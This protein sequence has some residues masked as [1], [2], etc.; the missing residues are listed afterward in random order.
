MIVNFFLITIIP[1]VIFCL[2]LL[3]PSSIR[4][5]KYKRF[6]ISL[7][8]NS[9]LY[10]FYYVSIDLVVRVLVPYFLAEELISSYLYD[11]NLVSL[12]VAGYSLC[13]ALIHAFILK[14][15][16]LPDFKYLL[17]LLL[18]LTLSCYLFYLFMISVNLSIHTYI[19]L[20]FTAALKTQDQVLMS[21]CVSRRY[22]EN[23]RITFKFGFLL[24]L[25][26][27]SLVI[28][29]PVY[30]LDI[31]LIAMTIVSSMLMVKVKK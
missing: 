28:I 8:A 20:A 17:L 3:P 10:R 16:Q 24:I 19:I 12:P 7:H 4:S 23:M 6:K 1:E 13:G 14:R 11:V 29:Y 30:H 5:L 18:S 2:Y 21:Y 22:F 31:I 9:F 15:Q 26:S 27:V 25:A